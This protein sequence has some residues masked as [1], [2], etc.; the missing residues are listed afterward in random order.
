MIARLDGASVRYLVNTF[1]DNCL[2]ITLCYPKRILGPRFVGIAGSLHD[3][4]FH[5]FVS[6]NS[7]FENMQ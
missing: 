1:S 7:D 5:D 2:S 4:C 6:L 3:H